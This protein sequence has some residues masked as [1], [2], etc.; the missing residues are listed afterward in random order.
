MR[1]SRCAFFLLLA[2]GALCQAAFGQDDNPA[3]AIAPI[4]RRLPPTNGVPISEETR[5]MLEARVAEWK[6]R[7]WEI[8][9]KE[10]AADVGALVK[11][12]DL[13]LQ[14][15]EFYQE[16]EIPIAT[17]M[18][19]L[20]A[21]RHREIDEADTASWTEQRGLV[22]RGYQSSIDESYQPYGLEI[23]ESLDLSKPVPLLVWL[24]GRGDKV[25]DLHFLER[26]RT[27]SQA[28]GG[29]VKEQ[30]EVIILHPFGRQC[31]GWKHAGEIDVFE[32]IEAVREDYP[33][34]PDRIALAGFSMGGAGAWHIGAHYRDRFCAVHAGAGF[35]ETKEY[36]RLTPETYPSE[37]EQILW[38]VYDAPDYV[39][40]FLNGPVLAYSG[41]EDKQKQAADLMEREL[42]AVGHSLHH[43]IGE[44]MGHK[45]NEESVEEIWKWLRGAWKEGRT[46]NASRVS[47]QT[48]TLRYPG[49][50]WLQL[51]G[52]EKHWN[53]SVALAEWDREAATI[54][55]ELE[56][57]TALVI[58]GNAD[59]DLGGVTLRIGEEVL[60]SEDPGFPI[61]ALSLRLEGGKW[62][63][64]EPEENR[65][66]PGVQG[67]IDDAFLGRFIVV[68][69]DHSPAA[70]AFARWLDFELDHFRA[71]W[72]ALMRGEFLEKSSDDLDSDDIRDANLVLWGDPDS[73]PMLAEIVDRLPIEWSGTE[74]RFRGKRGDTGSEVPVL[75][76]PNPLNPD[77]Y[78]VINSG[79][80]FRE[81]HDRTNS[82]QNPKLPDWA[83]IGLDKDPDALAPGRILDA[84]F[85]DEEWK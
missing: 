53:S 3:G 65:K 17:G 15:G 82:L 12:V 31:V 2:V 10:H 66:R 41:A 5:T 14:H 78:V 52:L 73:N 63:W 38:Q 50:H 20:A 33:I 81:G 76:F 43:V 26:C 45:Y 68:P 46:R 9:F 37:I 80:T 60:R 51:R 1:E 11:A 47:W 61:G 6:D 16:K 56:N 7:V 67:P 62:T 24:H 44:G 39:R 79:L 28:F 27:K 72:R 18:L 35:A 54:E 64:G 48:P 25:T 36:N 30:E 13:A 83:I 29:F 4:E 22:I 75:I 19:E 85:F 8:D 84:G 70:P 34:D 23:P 55:L 57:V 77:R 69:P 40:N 42:K 74:F 58:R 71:R 49:Y 32:A 59:E 21:R